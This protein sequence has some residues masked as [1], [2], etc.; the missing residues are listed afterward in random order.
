MRKAHRGDAFSK[1]YRQ[2]I[3]ER[4]ALA[5]MLHAKSFDEPTKRDLRAMIT[6]AVRN[7]AAMQP[8]A[9][10]TNLKGRR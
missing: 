6:D 1:S 5:A 4:D 7:T 9:R 2:M 10:R 8:R 3:D